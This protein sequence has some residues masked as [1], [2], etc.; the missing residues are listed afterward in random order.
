MWIASHVGVGSLIH[1]A[2]LT[3]TFLKPC[4]LCPHLPT[5]NLSPNV[6][7]VHSKLDRSMQACYNLSTIFVL[8]YSIH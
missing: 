3:G 6:M 7:L 5:I 4:T 8:R 1:Q 2:V